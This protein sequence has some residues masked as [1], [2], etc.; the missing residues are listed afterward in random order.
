MDLE[1]LQSYDDR[2]GVCFA[3]FLNRKCWEV[4]EA[5][6]NQAL[7]IC[8]LRQCPVYFLHREDLE[9]RFAAKFRYLW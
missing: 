8:M 4:P 6:C 1:E 7:H 5:Y 9:R 2:R 3:F